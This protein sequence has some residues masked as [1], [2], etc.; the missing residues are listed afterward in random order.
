MPSLDWVIVNNSKNNGRLEKTITEMTATFSNTIKEHTLPSY[1]AKTIKLMTNEN[2]AQERLISKMRIMY[3]LAPKL[4]N[5]ISSNIL[6]NMQSILSNINTEL[7]GNINTLLSGSSANIKKCSSNLDMGLI[8]C[9]IDIIN[10]LRGYHTNSLLRPAFIS[11]DIDDS[12][13]NTPPWQ[14]WLV[15]EYLFTFIRTMNSELRYMCMGF[16]EVHNSATEPQHV[17][18]ILFGSKPKLSLTQYDNTKNALFDVRLLMFVDEIPRFL[19]W[20]Q[21]TIFIMLWQMLGIMT[22]RDY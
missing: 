18:R 3:E 15:F 4:R 2:A 22:G 12:I 10:D 11:V 21:P 8:R 7:H 19:R 9:G 1:V 14:W 13:L 17:F 16:E 5:Y 20:T 6:Q